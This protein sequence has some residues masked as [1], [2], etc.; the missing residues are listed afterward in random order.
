MQTS[1]AE[2]PDRCP[3]VTGCFTPLCSVHPVGGGAGSADQAL[4]CLH[5]LPSWFITPKAHHS[6]N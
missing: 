2:S 1:S 5:W 3:S 6:P 4:P